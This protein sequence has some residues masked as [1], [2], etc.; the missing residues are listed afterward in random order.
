MKAKRNVLTHWLVTASCSILLA[1]AGP[2]WAQSI[3]GPGGVPAALEACEA[4]L[5]ACLE[6]PCGVIPGDGWPNDVF[7]AGGAP[8]S[9]QQPDP[10][11]GTFT[12]VNTALVWE[13]KT[14][15]VGE[16]VE[17]NIDPMPVVCFDVSDVNNR[18][19]WSDPTDAD[20]SDPDGRAFT[21]FLETLNHTCGGE[22]WDAAYC[23][24][25]TDCASEPIPYCGLAGHTDWR[26]PTVKELQSLVDYSVF[27][28]AA[29]FPGP[30]WSWY[31]WSTTSF[32]ENT[33]EA[34]DVV[35][36]GGG[37]SRVSKDTCDHVRAVRGGW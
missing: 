11:D 6:T 15:E 37:V 7:P 9:Y 19:D 35:F 22:S 16:Y 30:A 1:L 14:G 32:A 23:E 29:S 4:D 25:D 13:I 3:W 17:C 27:D 34:W 18:Y 2:A 31:Y 21:V 36:L 26:L 10:P 5:A 24:D 8:L 20:Y 28:P 33:E 12:D